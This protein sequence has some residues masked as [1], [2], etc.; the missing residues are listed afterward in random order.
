MPIKK[1]ELEEIK[2]TS[3]HKVKTLLNQFKEWKNWFSMGIDA[4]LGNPCAALFSMSANI[5]ILVQIKTSAH[6]GFMRGPFD[7]VD[8]IRYILSSI[9]ALKKFG[10]IRAV[11]IED[12]AY[13]LKLGAHQLG[14]LGGPIR[15]EIKYGFPDADQ[16]GVVNISTLKKF[17]TGKGNAK[18]AAMISAAL[19][20]YRV[21]T[22][23][24]T[25]D[26][27]DAIH[28]A[29]YG[30]FMT[31]AAQPGMV[32]EQIRED[33]QRQ[34]NIWADGLKQDNRK[35]KV[36]RFEFENLPQLMEWVEAGV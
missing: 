20:R 5:I 11:F 17:A 30:Y 12:Y 10:P 19:N 33:A 6:Q 25:D 31:L 28:A 26:E 35:I 34:L 24:E 14:E 7:D 13:N 32:E 4:S 16:K 3:I 36:V 23:I 18:K 8:R 2:Q 27:A 29:V 21:D 1:S 15:E 9:R 22:D